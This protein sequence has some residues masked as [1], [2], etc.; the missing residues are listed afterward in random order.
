MLPQR[1]G[2]VVVP[3]GTYETGAIRLLSNVNLHLNDGATLLFVFEPELYPIVETRWEGLD[4][5]NLSP[6]IYAKDAKNVALTGKGT[7][8]AAPT[9][10]NGGH[11]V[12]RSAMAGKRVIPASRTTMPARACCAWPKTESTAPNASSPPK[13]ACAP[14]S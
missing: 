2:M 10:R 3:D 6:C 4:C 14:S 9:T 7:L 8:T 1:G 12:A 5:F 13:T 11:G